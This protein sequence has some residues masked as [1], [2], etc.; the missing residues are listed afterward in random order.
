VAAAGVKLV[1]SLQEACP[2]TPA[3]DTRC[4]RTAGTTHA[5]HSTARGKHSMLNHIATV[6]THNKP[7]AA[8][9]FSNNF[10]SH[11]HLNHATPPHIMPAPALIHPSSGREM[12][13][14]RH[15]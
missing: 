14:S 8:A 7:H 13:Y 1:P 15:I 6:A 2:S 11:M 4:R 9:P 10:T 3:T 12:L 5:Q